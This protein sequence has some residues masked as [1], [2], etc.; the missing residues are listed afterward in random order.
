[1]PYSTATVIAST[2]NVRR[3]GTIDAALVGTLA[4]GTIVQVHA[5]A[6]NWYEVSSGATRG[7]VHGDFLHLN[8]V[9]TADGF[10][11]HDDVLCSTPLAARPP[12]VI[13]AARLAG[14][15]RR[16]GETWNRYGGMLAPLCDSV[17]VV[18]SAAVAVLCVESSGKGFVGDR[19]VIR[20]ENHVFWDHWGKR[21]PAAYN[22]FFTHDTSKRWTGHKYR[23]SASAPWLA[24]HTGQDAEWDAFDIARRL[25]EPAA[26]RSI[27]MGASQIMGFNHGVLGYDS[28]RAMFDHFSADERYHVL[29]LFDF[30][31]GPARTSRMLEALRREEYEQFATYY[32]GNGQAAVYGARIRGVIA[33]FE[34]IAPADLIHHEP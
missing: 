26:L 23:A 15:A 17:D 19:M 34:K 12:T 29:G 5:R 32:N 6:G 22:T 11:C 7:F 25:N 21:D 1:M 20:F 30:V 24:A 10:L 14:T 33:A 18:P 13:D 16:A 4:R 31:K 2:L 9:P 28:A 27:S 8:E 3:A